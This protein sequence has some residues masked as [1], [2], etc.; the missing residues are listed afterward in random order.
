VLF[1]SP[2]FVLSSTGPLLQHC[3][4][5]THRG[6]SP[7]RLYSLSNTGSLLALATFP[8]LFEPH[9]T[10]RMQATAWSWGFVLYALCCGFCA[11]KIWRARRSQ[12]GASAVAAAEYQ[13]PAFT[14][15]A[16]PS[17]RATRHPPPVL[18]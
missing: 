13:K 16:I 5:A 12:D 17:T 1:R 6:L 14:S 4:S 3:F 15:A 7:Y 11:L 8:F 2:Y 18:W 9:L 10:R